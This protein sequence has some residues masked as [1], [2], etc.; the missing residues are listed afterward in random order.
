R[1][2]FTERLKLEQGSP[3]GQQEERRNKFGLREISYSVEDKTIPAKFQK[4]RQ[5]ND[6]HIKQRKMLIRSARKLK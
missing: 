3:D 4:L 2:T 6:E 1:M 5:K